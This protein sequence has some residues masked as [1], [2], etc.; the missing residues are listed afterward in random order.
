VAHHG[1]DLADGAVAPPA[2]ELDQIEVPELLQVEPD[3]FA[4]S[5]QQL[6]EG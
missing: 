5:V 3:F 6:R 4:V 2:D 1:E